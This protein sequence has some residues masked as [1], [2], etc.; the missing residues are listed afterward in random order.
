MSR[1]AATWLVT[2]GAGFIGSTLVGQLLADGARVTVLD[3]LST[4]EP[5]WAERHAAALDRGT[6]RLVRASVV[7]LEAVESAMAGSDEVAHLA[8]NTDIAG[9]ARD[10]RLDR[11]ATLLGTW[12]VCEA[13]RRHGVTRL[14][15]ASSGVVYGHQDRVPTP[16]H[17]TPLRPESHYAAAKLAGEALISGFAHLG[18]WHALAFR[19][20]NTIGGTSNHGVVHDFVV[21]LLRDPTTL[22]VLGDGRQA[23][24]YIA[25]EDLVDG[26]LHAS[27]AAPTAPF[28]VYNLAT[29]G[30]LT[31]DRVAALVAEGLGVDV[32]RLR[33]VYRGDAGGAA[34]GSAGSGG[35]PGDTP[36]VD[37]DPSALQELG[38]QP[39]RS[40]AEAVLDAA[41]AT[42][43]R[44]V[45]IG[46]PFRTGQERRE[47]LR[48]GR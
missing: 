1:T 39:R 12:N 22:E 46:P 28:A 45:A 6:L 32:A 11:D 2:G 44:L 48:A 33:I 16:E 7:D 31:V 18:G 42:R 17:G 25:V 10:P 29:R 14:V 34:T 15:Y 19:F 38:W 37:L 5:D 24:P 35:W 4:S 21:K 20:G 13:M 43:A 26:V 41:R 8:A 40:A 3:D 9:G 23:K 36:V 47:L 30:T 27:R